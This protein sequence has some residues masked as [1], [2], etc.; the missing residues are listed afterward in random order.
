MLPGTAAAAGL[1]PGVGR[2]SLS[3]DAKTSAAAPATRNHS[4]PRFSLRV[5][6]NVQLG[7]AVRRRRPWV[8]ACKLHC[9]LRKRGYFKKKKK[10]EVVRNTYGKAY[11]PDGSKYTSWPPF[12]DALVV[13]TISRVFSSRKPKTLNPLNS[14]SPASAPSPQPPRHFCVQ[15]FDPA[16]GEAFHARLFRLAYFTEFRVLRV[17]V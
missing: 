17:Q 13:Q 9:F 10:K 15:G 11:P 14:N 6:Y 5:L 4:C 12:P 2:C 1:N 3:P 8:I 7:A 16:Y